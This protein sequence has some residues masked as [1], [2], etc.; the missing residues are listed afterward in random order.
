MTPTLRDM[1]KDPFPV[2]FRTYEDAMLF[3]ECI[4][5]KVSGFPLVVFLIQSFNHG[6]FLNR[7][8]TTALYTA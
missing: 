3:M 1:I 8:R 4:R 2:R 7:Y 5:T 6:F